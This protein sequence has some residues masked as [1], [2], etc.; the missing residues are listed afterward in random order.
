MRRAQVGVKPLETL[1]TQH[2]DVSPGLNN[3]YPN[4]RLTVSGRRP[5]DESKRIKRFRHL[6]G[7]P[8]S[9]REHPIIPTVQSI[10]PNHF[11]SISQLSDGRKSAS[12]PL[13][14]SPRKGR[15]PERLGMEE[16][17]RPK[18]KPTK[19]RSAPTH[20]LGFSSSDAGQRPQTRQ[21]TM[22]RDRPA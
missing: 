16:E 8:E 13:R 21:Q 10:Y 22:V 5:L 6:A 14:S 17:A 3:S 4:R 20:Q 9:V 11:H 19:F 1:C 7:L 18:K 15:L 12:S 2:F